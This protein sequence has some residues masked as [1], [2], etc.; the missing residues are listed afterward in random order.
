MFNIQQKKG[1]SVASW[2]IFHPF[3]ETPIL[4]PLA[5]TMIQVVA[6]LHWSGMALSLV[7]VEISTGRRHQ[8]RAHT[9]HAGH[10]TVRDGSLT[11]G[12]V[13]MGENWSI[14]L[15]SSMFPPGL[16]VC[17]ELRSREIKIYMTQQWPRWWFQ[18][19][20]IFTLTRGNDPIWRAYFSDGLKPPT[21]G[22]FLLH[23][24]S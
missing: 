24:L 18:I 17:N 21:S 20:S 1:H 5:S 14:C 15:F 13:L 7:A 8:I 2:I 9:S 12:S 10:V 11:V 6:H 4:H 22:G 3:C 23:I 19:F 16:L